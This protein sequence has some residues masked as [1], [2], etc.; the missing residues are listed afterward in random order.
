MKKVIQAYIDAA[1]K[2]IS[3]SREKESRREGEC[4]KESLEGKAIERKNRFK[5]LKWD[6]KKKPT[7]FR[8]ESGFL[9]QLSK[10]HP[11]I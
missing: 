4:C 3:I 8:Y 1:A 5:S 10:F 9:K 7:Y 2:H 6:L 11:R